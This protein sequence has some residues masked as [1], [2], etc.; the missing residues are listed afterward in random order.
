MIYRIELHQTETGK[1]LPQVWD[2]D[3]SG[4]FPLW[5]GDYYDEMCDAYTAA[6]YEFDQR[7][8]VDREAA[9]LARLGADDRPG[10]SERD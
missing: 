3:K 10:E 7:C 5:E 1:F 8:E 6:E 2:G 9:S 4:G